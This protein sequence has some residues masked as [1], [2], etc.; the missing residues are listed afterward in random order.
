MGEPAPSAAHVCL[1]C[2]RSTDGVTWAQLP[3]PTDADVALAAKLPNG[4]PFTGDISHE[5]PTPPEPPPP[6]AEGGAQP[7]PLGC[8]VRP[9]PL[10]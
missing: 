8:L 5:F 9:R 6:V 1:C 2:P 10:G 4:L 3:A 7:G